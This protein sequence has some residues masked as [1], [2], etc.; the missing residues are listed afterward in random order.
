VPFF[1]P[2]WI[3]RRAQQWTA[4]EADR[5]LAE[6]WRSFVPMLAPSRGWMTITSSV[7]PAAVG[8]TYDD[9]VAGRTQA[10]HGHVLSL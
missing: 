10:E 7:G 1:A 3:R 5:R 4:P 6:A 2:T 8:R 9:L